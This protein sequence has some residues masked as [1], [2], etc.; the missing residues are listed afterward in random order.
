MAAPVRRRGPVWVRSAVTP[1]AG[2]DG[3]GAGVEVAFAVPRRVGTAVTRNRI[4]RR[5][6]AAMVELGP[7]VPRGSYLIGADRGAADISFPALVATL[8]NLLVN[9][10]EKR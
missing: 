6:R 2:A 9:Q 10:G 8:R 3:S 5:L 1:P 7:E 4:R